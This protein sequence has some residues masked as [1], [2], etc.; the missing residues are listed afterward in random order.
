MSRTGAVVW[1][2]RG[3]TKSFGPVLANDNVSIALRRGEI[4][5]LVGQNG[6]GKSTLVKTLCGAHPADSG[7]ILHDGRPVHIASP[8]AARALGIATVFQEFSLV[9]NMT[10][11]ENIFLGRWP[12]RSLRLDW[13]TMRRETERVLSELQIE[14]SPDDL[15]GDLSVARRQ[16]VE[17]AKAFAQNASMLVLDEPTAALAAR[18]TEHLFTL[19]RRMRDQ[20]A[21]ILYISHRL[22]EVVRLVDVLTIMRNGRV[23]STADETA[24]DVSFIVGRMVGQ[25]IEE[26]YPKE[27]NATATPLLEVSRLSTAEG[28]SDVSFTLHRGE[29]LGFGGMMG[30][31]RSRIARALF[32]I[33]RPTAGEIRIAGRTVAF[34]SPAEAVAAGLAFLPEDRKTDGLFFN[35]DGCENITV[36]NLRSLIRGIQLDLAREREVGHAVIRQM[37]ITPSAGEKFVDELSGGNQQK[38]ILGRWLYAGAEIFMLDEPTQGLD[39]AAK[40]AVFRLINE[41][42]RAGKGVILISS[43]DDE[44]LAMSDTVAI[45]RRGRLVRIA[46]ARSITKADLLQTADEAA[47]S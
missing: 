22:D 5:G 32:G 44:L 27:R 46:D 7:T 36:A 4:H 23:V 37:D 14:V 11:A 43:H 41:L 38:I 26:Y 31:G 39:I 10:V 30:A 9:P 20:Q 15:V 17:I 42:T 28:V 25:A 45:V 8:L 19:L 16:T 24:I 29:V 2:L 3:I 12:G 1:E 33:D 6:S 35:F 47:R 21:A 34:S 18:E 13:R 40:T